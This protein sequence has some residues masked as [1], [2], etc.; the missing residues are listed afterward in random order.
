[1]DIRL[2]Y[3]TYTD[4]SI[5]LAE[6]ANHQAALVV[7]HNSEQLL[8]ASVNM[9]DHKIP[10]GYICIKDWSENEGV[11]DSLIENRIVESP[12]YFLPSGFV[13]VAICK[14]LI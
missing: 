9:P 11:L 10:E 4:C 3:G 14:L 2:A 7:I 1:M 5:K 12:E 8:K 6:Y 13:D